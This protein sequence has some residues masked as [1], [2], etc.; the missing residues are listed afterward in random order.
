MAGLSYNRVPSSCSRGILQAE[1]AS[2]SHGHTS[3]ANE[4]AQKPG[5]RVSGGSVSI[6]EAPQK[7]RSSVGS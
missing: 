1:E 2:V 4:H 7:P 5:S 6:T 3:R